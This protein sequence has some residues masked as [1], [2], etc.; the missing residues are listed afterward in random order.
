MQSE[1]QQHADFNHVRYANCWEDADILIRALQP[2]G[3]HCLSIGSAGDNSFSLLAA[4][5]RKVTISEMNPAQVSCIKLRIAAYKCLSHKQFLTLLGELD[6]TPEER[7][8]LY[9][10]CLPDLD[11]T[12]QEYW[13]HFHEHIQNG[14]GRAGKFE[15]YFTLFRDKFLPWV[16][17]YKHTA[18]LLTS[19]SARDRNAFY[20]EKW[21]TWRW[22]LLFKLFFSR[23]VMGRL[24]RDPAFFKY[25]EGSV[26]DRI[27][28]RTR[29]A[30]VTLE[31]AKNPY[32]Q[33]IL[34]GRYG[35][36]LPHA[37][38]E[39]NFNTIRENLDRVT[40]DPRPLEA[41][42]NDPEQ[43]YDAFNL[44]DIFEYMSEDNTES[45]LQRIHSGSSHGARLAYWNMLAPRSRPSQMASKLKALGELSQSLFHED[46][47]FFYSAFIVEESVHTKS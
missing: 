45:L 5:A 40:I 37:L 17:S 9:Q 3:R 32:L 27:L 14:F 43:I 13:H 2:E 23:F 15:N 36:A 39:E 10:K 47:A 20:E 22:R 33:W 29:H 25:V 11:S 26:A 46:K 44:S 28:M 1:I 41:V 16:H 24:G 4:G 19:K 31:P 7:V 21:N 34:M 38:R 8:E 12:T 6:A 30:L 35:T 18:E 42:L